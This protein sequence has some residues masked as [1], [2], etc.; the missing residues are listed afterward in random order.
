[1]SSSEEGL[2]E[3]RTYS[4]RFSHRLCFSVP[5]AAHAATL[6]LRT[7]RRRSFQ[8]TARRLAKKF[9]RF[10][11]FSL[12]GGPNAASILAYLHEPHCQ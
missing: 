1:M 3:A 10:F 6:P 2:R 11:V 8:Q 7:L 5:I 4:F 12:S 9:L